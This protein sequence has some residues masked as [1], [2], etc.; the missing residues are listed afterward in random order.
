MKFA[1]RQ[2][3]VTEHQ[4][5]LVRSP[6]DLRRKQIVNARNVDTVAMGVLERLQQEILFRL[7]NDRQRANGGV[8]MFAC[9]LHQVNDAGSDAFGVKSTDRVGVEQQ[10]ELVASG[11]QAQ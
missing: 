4:C 7:R 10:L 9:G 5:S 3:V 8:R 11:C 1:I 2:T 6:A